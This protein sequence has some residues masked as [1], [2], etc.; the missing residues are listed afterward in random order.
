MSILVYFFVATIFIVTFA[1]NLLTHKTK[2]KLFKVFGIL[3]VLLMTASLSSCLKSDDSDDLNKK[4]EDWVKEVNTEI[5]A[6]F[7][8]YQGKLYALADSATESNL[9]YDSIPA[10]WRINRD[11]TLDLLNV[12]VEYLVKRMPETQKALKDSVCKVGNVNIHVPMVYNYYYHSPLVMYVYP[13]TV[14]F[15]INYE[16]ETHQVKIYFRTTETVSNSVAQYMMKDANG[17]VD[18]CMIQLYPE[19]L[20]MDG[21]FQTQFPAESYLIWLGTK[22]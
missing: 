8:S 5:T 4:W 11:S 19:S 14:S 16:G 3:A 18:K 10:T 7:G 1:C 13:N 17:N 15:P 2:M 22:Y 9:K 12:P 6:S 21:R 20:Y